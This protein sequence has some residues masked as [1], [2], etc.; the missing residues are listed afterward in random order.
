[1]RSTVLKNITDAIYLFCCLHLGS[2]DGLKKDKS[3][4]TKSVLLHII[5]ATYALIVL[6][7]LLENINFTIFGENF[8]RK[9]T[10]V[11][12]INKDEKRF[13]SC[14]VCFLAVNLAIFVTF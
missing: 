5:F 2:N 14:F 9:C 1:M 4:H 11:S 3:S 8:L 10:N 12:R 6:N 7:I 13:C